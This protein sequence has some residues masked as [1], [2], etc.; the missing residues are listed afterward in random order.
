MSSSHV[1]SNANMWFLSFPF[2]PQKGSRCYLPS[3]HGVK[4]ASYAL[5]SS[6]IDARSRRTP[7][8]CAGRRPSPQEGLSRT[9]SSSLAWNL[10]FE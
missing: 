7:R 2:I 10:A 9:I 6:A 4:T 5:G 8:R 3:P 1:S